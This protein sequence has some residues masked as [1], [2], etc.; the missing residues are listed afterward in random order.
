MKVILDAN[1]LISLYTPP[2]KALENSREVWPVLGLSQLIVSPEI[3]AEV[4]NAFRR[5][6]FS[7]QNEEVKA[8]LSDI[9]DRC[10]VVRLKGE[11]AG[12]LPDERD[13]HLF[14]L[15]TENDADIIIS[16]DSSLQNMKQISGL[17]IMPLRQFLTDYGTPL[18]ESP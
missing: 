11:Y 3:F 13:R 7:L 10:K 14:T 15:A 12:E 6:D 4:E 8:I 16:G 9:L 17:Q 2:E 5:S 1:I 18:P